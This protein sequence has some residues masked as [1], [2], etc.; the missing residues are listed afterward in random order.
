[1]KR[2]RSTTAYSTVASL[3]GCGT[4]AATSGGSLVAEPGSTS[5][6]AQAFAFAG[7]GGHVMGDFRYDHPMVISTPEVR[8][9]FSKC[10]QG[11]LKSQDSTL[12]LSAVDRCGS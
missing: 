6:L 2:P 10:L 12:Q 1:M 8:L 5:Y 11:A 3:A 7:Q 4:R 9:G